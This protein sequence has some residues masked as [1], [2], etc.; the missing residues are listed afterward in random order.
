MKTYWGVEIRSG[1]DYGADQS[2]SYQGLQ[3]KRDAKKSL[4]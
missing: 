2:G 1:P 3:P 4:E